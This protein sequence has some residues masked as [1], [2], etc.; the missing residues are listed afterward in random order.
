MS[1]EFWQSKPAKPRHWESNFLT[2]SEAVFILFEHLNQRDPDRMLKTLYQW[3][4]KFIGVRDLYKEV[5]EQ[6]RLTD[7]RPKIRADIVELLKSANETSEFFRGKF[8]DFLSETKDNSDEEFF[9]AYSKLPALT[10]QDYAEANQTVMTDRWAKVDPAAAEFSVQGKPWES[11]RRLRGNDYLMKMATGG[12]TSMPLA[13]TM[14][15]H[16]MFSML[17]TFFKCWYRMVGDRVSGCSSF[18][19][20]THTTSTTW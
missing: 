17:F 4:F 7:I 16:H 18:T 15:K 10:K 12:S 19:Q 9:A 3:M 6:D 5:V 11:I 13:V 14:T 8:T 2:Y 1:N 20:R